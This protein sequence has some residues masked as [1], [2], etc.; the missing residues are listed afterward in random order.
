IYIRNRYG[1]HVAKAG[2]GCV[3]IDAERDASNGHVAYG[4]VDAGG[5]RSG[6]ER[7]FARGQHSQIDSINREGFELDHRWLSYRA[8]RTATTGARGSDSGGQPFLQ[9]ARRSEEHTSEL[10][11][12]YDLVCRLLL[13]KKKQSI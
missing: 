2:A 8:R 4:R 6:T 3:A 1:S 10:Q 9:I 7:P 5:V 13:E 11:S 12:P